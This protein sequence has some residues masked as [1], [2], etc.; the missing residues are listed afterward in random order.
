ML[1]SSG[2][3]TIRRM[4][5]VVAM[6]LMASGHSVA[7]GFPSRAATAPHTVKSAETVR[8]A[9]QPWLR[10]IESVFSKTSDEEVCSYVQ[11]LGN[12]ALMVSSGE[13]GPAALAQRILAPPPDTTRPWIGVIV[14]DSHKDLPAGRWQQ[15]ASAI[16]FAAEYHDDTNTIYLRSDI[17]QVPLI[18]GLLLVHEMRHW[19]QARQPSAAAESRLRK[20][21]DAYETEFRILDALGLPSYENLLRAEHLRIKRGPIQPD[22]SSPLLEQTF[23]RFPASISKQI[24]ATEITVRAAFAELDTLPADRALQGKIDLLRSLGY[25]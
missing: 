14:I 5:A 22:V 3:N 8:A 19:W 6:Y 16:D 25:Q 10:A 1:A 15:I 23:G 21:V 12:A 9:L 24:A 20:E 13:G 7:Q 2:L 4:F 18:R 17:P 11:V